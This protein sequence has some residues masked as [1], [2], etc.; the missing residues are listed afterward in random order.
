MANLAASGG[1][2]VSTPADRIFAEPGT[3]TG[4]IGVFAIIPSFERALADWGVTTD[5][6][7]ITPLSGQP[8]V[9]SGLSPEIAAML[10]TNVEHSYAHFIGIV[11]QAR[12]RTPAQIDAIAQGRVWDGG[13]A[14]QIGLV[15]EF[16]GLDEALAYA[17]KAAKLDSWHAV[18]LGQSDD[19]WASLLQR[20]S[21]DEDSAPPAQGRDFAAALADRQMNL[22]GRAL[23]EAER[24]VG[25]RGIQAYCL[26]CAAQGAMRQPAK[27]ELTN[28]ARFARLVGLR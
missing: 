2:W 22:A 16:G 8:D 20:F 4:S 7:P 23:G 21:G 10:Q 18:F 6:V 13:T 17:A 11:G 15:D 1:Y 27:G 25:A 14:R 24:L 19:Q 26:E 5:G 28:L 3:I 9:I 12:K